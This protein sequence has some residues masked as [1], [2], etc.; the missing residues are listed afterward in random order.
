MKQNLFL[1]PGKLLQVSEYMYFGGYPGEHQFK[2]VSNVDFDG[3]IDGVLVDS[4]SVDLSKHITAFGISPGC[5][6]KVIINILWFLKINK[7][8]R[9]FI[10][11]FLQFQFSS[12]VAFKENQSGYIRY[13]NTSAEQA[14]DLSLR[15]K[16]NVP[17]GIILLAA[18]RDRSDPFS[19]SLLDGKLV[20]Y[21]NSFGI[22]R[23]IIR[24]HG[25]Q[26][27]W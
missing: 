2:S 23:F 17:N 4:T 9:N 6:A 1:G 15:F 13:P 10:K 20:S 7:N 14:I 22:D 3:C 25:N 16:T 19:L 18:T 26:S 11:N 5:P 24:F 8:A 21:L 27:P 12:I